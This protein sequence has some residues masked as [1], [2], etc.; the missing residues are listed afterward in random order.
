MGR[1]KSSV[2][3]DELMAH[4]CLQHFTSRVAADAAT[5]ACGRP[6]ARGTPEACERAKMLCRASLQILALHSCRPAPQP[7][8]GGLSR[9]L[10]VPR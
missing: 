9:F 1:I 2:L 3:H 4:K 10:C 8:Q 7:V 5:D 6:G